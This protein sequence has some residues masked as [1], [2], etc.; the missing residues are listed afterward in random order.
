MMTDLSRYDLDNPD[1][2]SRRA[3][4]VKERALADEL[5]ALQKRLL[6]VPEYRA[7]E[8]RLKALK[9]TP[10]DCGCHCT[11]WCGGYNPC[12]QACDTHMCL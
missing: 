1:H 10:L 6:D 7:L 5:A 11:G 2:V 12:H 8:E 9:N 3:R 4:Q